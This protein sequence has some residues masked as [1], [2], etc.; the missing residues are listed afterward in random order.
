MCKWPCYGTQCISPQ[1][2]IPQVYAYSAEHTGSIH[3]RLSLAGLRMNGLVP[4]VMSKNQARLTLRCNN[5]TLLLSNTTE[6]EA[7][8]VAH[9]CRHLPICLET[10]HLGLHTMREVLGVVRYKYVKKTLSLERRSRSFITKYMSTPIKRL[11]HLTNICEFHGY[12]PFSAFR[13]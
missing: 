12:S 6:P 9:H 10:H 4:N 2:S 11:R 7:C 8:V 1:P 5:N 13:C 3:S